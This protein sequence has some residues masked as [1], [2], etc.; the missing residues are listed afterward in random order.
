MIKFVVCICLDTSELYD[1]SHKYDCGDMICRDTREQC[2]KFHERTS[3]VKSDD[4]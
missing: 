2:R 3:D 1:C 4:K